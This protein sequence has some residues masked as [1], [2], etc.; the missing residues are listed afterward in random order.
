[1]NNTTFSEFTSFS[2][3]SLSCGV[4]AADAEQRNFAAGDDGL[5][6]G[7]RFE[8]VMEIGWWR[9]WTARD[10]DGLETNLKDCGLLI[11]EEETTA[12]GITDGVLIDRRPKITQERLQKGGLLCF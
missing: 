7:V 1:M 8:R 10:A 6:L 2:S 12:V 5:S 4:S 9:L 3:V 11:T